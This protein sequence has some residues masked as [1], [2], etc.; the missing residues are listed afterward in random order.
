M[1]GVVLHVQRVCAEVGGGASGMS[2]ARLGPS[3]GGASG[4]SAARLGPSR[5]GASGMS[6]QC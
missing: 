1:I 4:M 3:R 6:A 2:A 5:G